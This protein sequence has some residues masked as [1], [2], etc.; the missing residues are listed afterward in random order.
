[1]DFFRREAEQCDRVQDVLVY[2]CQYGGAGSGL[3]P[4]FVRRADLRQK[5]VIDVALVCVVVAG[6]VVV[7]RN[8]ARAYIQTMCSMRSD[9]ECY[10]ACVQAGYRR[11]LQQC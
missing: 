2:S 7:I 4:L 10:P 9:G 1:M 3:A 11:E 6:C 5:C 8:A